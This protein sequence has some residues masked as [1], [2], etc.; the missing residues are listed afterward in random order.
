MLLLII[1]HCQGLCCVPK[2]VY[3]RDAFHG[4][5]VSSVS[6]YPGKKRQAAHEGIRCTSTHPLAHSHSPAVHQ[7]MLLGHQTPNDGSW[8]L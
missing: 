2:H 4:F 3:A 1:V 7:H 8:R 5:L 6:C